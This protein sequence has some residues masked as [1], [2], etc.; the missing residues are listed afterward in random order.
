MT[1]PYKSEADSA[2]LNPVYVKNFEADKPHRFRAKPEA[3]AEAEP[4]AK[5]EAKLDAGP[6]QAPKQAP[7]AKPQPKA[8]PEEPKS[9]KSEGK[10]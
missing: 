7:E 10:A 8:K 3:K 5:P 2:T 1:S 4:E 9:A 6:D